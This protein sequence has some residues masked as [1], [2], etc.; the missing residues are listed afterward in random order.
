MS[1]AHV[2]N[3]DKA[4]PATGRSPFHLPCNGRPRANQWPSTRRLSR[5]RC[6]GVSPIIP[7]F[8]V[9]CSQ[10][11]SVTAS[12]CRRHAHGG[13]PGEGRSQ[14]IIDIRHLSVGGKLRAQQSVDCSSQESLSSQLL[15][16]QPATWSHHC[17]LLVAEK[18][19]RIGDTSARHF[20]SSP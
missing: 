19:G 9:F 18:P 10:L 11:S 16:F 2:R 1:H 7:I 3:A 6:D 13:A 20:V 4:W 5:S 8:P 12:C 14:N 15:H 17:R